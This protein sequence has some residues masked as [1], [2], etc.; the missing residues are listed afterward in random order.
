ML[1]EKPRTVTDAQTGKTVTYTPG[2]REY[3]TSDTGETPPFRKRMLDSAAYGDAISSFVQKTCDVLVFDPDTGRVLV[4]TRAKEPQPGDW[5]IGGRKYAGE[6]DEQAALRNL[7]REMGDKVADMAGG[8]LIKL[9][10]S[11]DVIWDTREHPATENEAGEQ[12]TGAHQAPTVFALPVS[13]A[14]FDAIARPNEEYSGQRWEDGFEIIESP[15]GAYHPAF[16]DMVHDMLEQV[17]RTD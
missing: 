10:E 4:V 7:R 1:L 12:V 5:V 11:Y 13:P 15:D 3:V 17:T 9:D 16:R 2:L 8:R 6:S 14:E